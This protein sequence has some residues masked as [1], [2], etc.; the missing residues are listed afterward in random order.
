MFQSVRDIPIP[1]DLSEIEH[2]EFVAFQESLA[3]L[4]EEWLKIQ[5]GEN[6]DQQMCV[7]VLEKRT[8]KR[9]QEAKS[10]LDLRLEV[11]EK[12]VEKETD[13]IEQE[14]QVA[15]R[16]LW[17][18]LYRAYAQSYSTITNQLK[19]LMGKE[20]FQAYIADKTIEFAGDVIQSD[21][22]MKTRMQQ[23]EE[24]KI[25]L[26]PQQCEADMKL[27]QAMFENQDE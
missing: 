4:E 18:R 13:R 19:E 22:Q 16:N 26:S 10:R 2:A 14:S 12:Q 21:S 9:K 20:S 3:A 27:I 11:I 25:R 8:A 17:K 15:E 1:D 5:S 24:M 23:P 7:Q 6:E